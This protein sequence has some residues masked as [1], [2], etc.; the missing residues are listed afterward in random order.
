MKATI[1]GLSDTVVFTG[2]DR[3]AWQCMVAMLGHATNLSSE[4]RYSI[5]YGA[6]MPRLLMVGSGQG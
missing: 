4:V 5:L 2:A 6:L 3:T 1:S